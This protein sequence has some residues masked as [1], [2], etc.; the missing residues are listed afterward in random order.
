M[1]F[2]LNPCSLLYQTL[3]PK[4]CGK[5]RNVLI[6]ILCV[7]LCLGLAYFLTPVVFG[8]LVTAPITG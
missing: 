2:T 7:I 1:Y 6:Q 4:T 5:I 8:N 3:G